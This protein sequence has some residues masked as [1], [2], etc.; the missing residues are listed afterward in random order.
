M[1]PCF[2]HKGKLP[3]RKDFTMEL[4]KKFD[5]VTATPDAR[6][7][8][9]DRVFCK[10]HQA[11]YDNA[12]S[13][14]PELLCFWED[15]QHQQAELLS[16]TDTSSTFFLASRDSIKLSEKGIREQLFSLHSLF[17][18]E[19]VSFFNKTYHLSLSITEIER[20]LLP[21]KPEDRWTDDY[22][23]RVRTYTQTIQDLSLRYTDILNQIFLY[24]DGREL[25]EQALH[26]LK[27]KCHGAAWNISSGKAR[28]TLK[29]CTL[30]LNGYFCNYHDLYGGG[31]WELD[32]DT[33]DILRGISHFETGGF[34][35][36]PYSI[37]RIIGTYD[38]RSDFHEF[39]DC[40]KILSLKMYKNHRVDIK[41]T[42]EEN[43]RQFTNDY[44]GTIC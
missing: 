43:A 6:I 3:F 36:S 37:S 26:E 18:G 16:G 30:M 40:D 4:L 24:T 25:S 20:S 7:S 27:G 10:A 19:V 22:E 44:L 35:Y 8:D 38:L 39:N 11:A 41:F 9:T 28:F 23:D 14:L 32:Q 13:T 33:K 12:K 5:A 29:K 15:M 2:Q 42:T 1:P 31:Y 34:S 21:Q 17:V